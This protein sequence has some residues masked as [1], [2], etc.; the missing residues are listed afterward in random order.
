MSTLAER[1][2]LLIEMYGA[3]HD[4]WYTA[5]DLADRLDVSISTIYRYL[6]AMEDDGIRWP[7]VQDDKHRFHI[8]KR[9]EWN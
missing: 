2:A 7:V 4:G 3:L 1:F 9:T 5:R 8:V 6:R